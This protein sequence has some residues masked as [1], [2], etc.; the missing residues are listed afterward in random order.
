MRSRMSGGVG[1]AAGAILP[2]RPDVSEMHLRCAGKG[3][4]VRIV[5][6]SHMGAPTRMRPNGARR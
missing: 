2:P 6:S 1:G 3:R 5:R 4:I